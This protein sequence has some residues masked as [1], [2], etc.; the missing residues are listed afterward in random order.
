MGVKVGSR[1]GVTGAGVEVG[2]P[3][4]TVSVGTGVFVIVGVKITTDVDVGKAVG[5]GG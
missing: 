1:V 2:S 4:G 5:P 3:A